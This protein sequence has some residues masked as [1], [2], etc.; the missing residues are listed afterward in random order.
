MK[1]PYRHTFQN[2][3]IGELVYLGKPWRWT[4]VYADGTREVFE[5]VRRMQAMRTG[6]YVLT[7]E[8]GKFI[9]VAPGHRYHIQE[10]MP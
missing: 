10:P 6:C 9:V 2:N 7:M 1:D 4:F 3:I 8:S 5:G